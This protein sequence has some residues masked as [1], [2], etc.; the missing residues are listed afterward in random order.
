MLPLLSIVV[1]HTLTLI[2]DN[3]NAPQSVEHDCHSLFRGVI[4]IGTLVELE[5]MSKLV[6]DSILVADDLVEKFDV[7]FLMV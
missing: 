2:V 7:T 3:M 4:C 5:E 1:E 6:D